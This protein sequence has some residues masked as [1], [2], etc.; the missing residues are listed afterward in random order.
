MKTPERIHLG[1]DDL[2]LLPR[3]AGC[4]IFKAY[5]SENEREKYLYVGKAKSLRERVR[6]Y[7]TPGQDDRPFVKFIRDRTEI[8]EYFI[9]PSEH[10]ALVLEN[11]LIKKHKPSYNIHLRD[12]K[13]YLS[14]RIET[15]HEWPRVEITRRIR[16]DKAVYLGPFSSASK[17]KE[18]LN[19]M[20]KIF[21]LRTC[22]DRKLYNRSRPCI[23]YDIKRCVAPCVNYCSKEEYK[24]LVEGALFFLRGDTDELVQQL[25]SQMQR[26]VE[27]ENYEEAAVVRDRIEAIQKT[28]AEKQ[29]LSHEL[30]QKGQD[31]DAIGFARSGASVVIA[32][33]FIRSGKVWDQ[34]SFQFNAAKLEDEEV[35]QQ[36][37]SQYYSSGVYIPHEILLPFSA[38]PMGL[39]AD[40]IQPRGQDKKAF[41][42]MA[43]L[44][45]EQ[46][47]ENHIKKSE[48]LDEVLKNIKIKLQLE[49]H[50][51]NMDCIDISHHQGSEVVASVVRFTNGVP[52]KD[53]YRKIKLKHDEVNDFAS[54]KEAISR[55]YKSK[56]DLPNL[57]VIDG[58]KGQL[59]S[60]VEVLKELGF[61]GALDVRALAKARPSD[62]PVDPLNPMNRERIFT[63]QKKNPF[64]LKED[65]QEELLLSFLRDEAHRFAIS[66]HRERKRKSLSISLLDEV[67]G[68][69]SRVKLK[70]LK[71]FGSV[72]AIQQASDFELLKVI[73]PKL[74][75]NLRNSLDKDR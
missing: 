52:N 23:E 20:Q 53:F 68:L 56:G 5:D 28:T 60:T 34:D 40:F 65:S 47:L 8:I 17:L 58:G 22:P 38:K 36:F 35:L 39:K 63:H 30:R 43:Q 11:E 25:N 9:T 75:E 48:R 54:M 18:T 26:L 12:D 74:L 37:L 14:L 49:Q 3:A 72:E 51:E 59:S 13:R 1:K 69:S 32:I 67:E 64:L 50:P 24:Q 29:M 57:L 45:A 31:Q 71:E 42:E 2:E 21:P 46:K 19:V 61:W 15:Q 73:K 10:D 55:R 62:E 66:F 41:V 4:Y 70:L 27:S 6:Q 7:F 33:I 44:N 16:K